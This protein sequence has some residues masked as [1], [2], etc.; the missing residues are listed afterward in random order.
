MMKEK[1]E[2]QNLHTISLPGTDVHWAKPG[3]EIRVDG[4]MFDI[5]SFSEKNGTYTFTGL[6]DDDETALNE[7]L[8]KDVN[9]KNESSNRLLSQLFQ[10]LQA[11]DPATSADNCLTIQFQNPTASFY[12]LIIPFAYK[13]ILTPPPRIDYSFA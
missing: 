5:K 10:W 11:V 6:F 9:Q 3:K 4:R 2:Q 8:E 1:L 7:Y 12:G 13:T